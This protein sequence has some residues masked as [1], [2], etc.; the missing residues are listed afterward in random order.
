MVNLDQFSESLPYH[1]IAYTEPLRNRALGVLL[2]I[3][4]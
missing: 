4:N 1:K 3:I 2:N